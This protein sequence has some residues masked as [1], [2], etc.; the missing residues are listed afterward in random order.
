[1]CVHNIH[2]RIFLMISIY[3]SMPCMHTHTRIMTDST[4]QWADRRRI[5]SL[6]LE[7]FSLCLSCTHAH[8]HTVKSRCLYDPTS[9]IPRIT[10]THTHT[11]PHS[12]VY[13]H[14]HTHTVKS[15]LP[16]QF[17]AEHLQTN[18]PHAHAHANTHIPQCY[19]STHTHTHTHKYLMHRLTYTH[20]YTHNYTHTCTRTLSLFH[21][22]PLVCVGGGATARNWTHT[23]P[24]ARTN[25]HA[26]ATL[27][28]THPP[29]HLYAAAGRLN[30]SAH[31]LCGGISQKS[32]C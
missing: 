11:Y 2:T 26:H 23:N 18:L 24:P 4:I 9:R 21:T 30:I 15:W 25:A 12:P 7:R 27:T 5:L 10:L 13:T 31:V 8:T 6:S 17:N 1:M 20:L 28:H 16:V 32:N 19:S 29:S 14:T 22:H 3:A